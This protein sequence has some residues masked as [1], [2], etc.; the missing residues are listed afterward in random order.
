MYQNPV[1]IEGIR[2]MTL[3]I[4]EKIKTG[5]LTRSS[6]F[7]LDMQSNMK[8]AGATDDEAYQYSWEALAILSTG[9]PNINLRLRG[10][11]SS[12][13]DTR[14]YTGIFFQILALGVS[15]LDAS[16]QI[17]FQQLY[18]IPKNVKISF[19]NSKPYHFWMTAFHA[20]KTSSALAAWLS[21]LGY[22]FKSTTIGRD[23]KR[24]FIVDAFGDENNK[25]RLDLALAAQG[26]AF[27]SESQKS[28]ST[29][30][31]NADIAL[32]ALITS[33]D[34]LTP[35]ATVGEAEGLFQGTGLAAWLRWLAIF[36]PGSAFHSVGRN[37]E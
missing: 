21:Q 4:F 27:G 36:A 2:L 13:K 34:N 10:F 20:R 33:G 8:K 30:E 17:R 14:K 24:A 28:L 35:L 26:A 16:A 12:F 32:K 3:E 22:Q 18:S 29:A 7:F 5:S 15:V 9:G 6:D 11:S 31:Y 19:D 25:I 23:P 1:M 37:D